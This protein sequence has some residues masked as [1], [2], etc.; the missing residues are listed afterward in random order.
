MSMTPAEARFEEWL[1][2]L[3]NEHAEIAIEEFTSDRLMS[4]YLKSPKIIHAPRLALVEGRTLL[5]THPR[6]AFILASMAVEM[7][8]RELILRPIVYGLVISESTASVMSQ[9]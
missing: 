6:A 8:L 4:Y 9:K 5:N 1:E 3:Y 2:E 7:G